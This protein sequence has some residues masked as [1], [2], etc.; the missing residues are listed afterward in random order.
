MNKF[1][2]VVIVVTFFLIPSVAQAYIEPGSGLMIVQIIVG[3][4]A[5]GLVSIRLF[6]KG[7]WAKLT[8]RSGDKA[9]EVEG[10]QN[11]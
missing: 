6:W 9:G 3:V 7:L 10:P 4:I 1:L 5:G 2:D 11:G 8:R